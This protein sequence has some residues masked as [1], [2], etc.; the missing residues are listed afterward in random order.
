ML[1][2][3]N[4]KRNRIQ[5]W[6]L[7]WLLFFLIYQVNRIEGRLI[8][9]KRTEIQSC[10]LRNFH[11]G[12][13]VSHSSNF[14]LFFTFHRLIDDREK[15]ILFAVEMNWWKFAAGLILWFFNFS[16]IAYIT[17]QISDLVFYKNI[18]WIIVR[19]FHCTY[20]HYIEIIRY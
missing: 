4:G 8:R 17:D 7:Y 3:K 13:F 10:E 2:T 1:F 5:W 20:M 11:L 12:K 6:Q 15:K 18:K 9:V 16:S 14:Y 19:L